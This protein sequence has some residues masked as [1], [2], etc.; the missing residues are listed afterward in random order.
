MPAH[1][2]PPDPEVLALRADKARLEDAIDAEYGRLAASFR[3]MAAELAGF[4]AHEGCQTARWWRPAHHSPSCR[5]IGEL[6]AVYLLH[7]DL[8]VGGMGV[9]T[10]L[11]ARASEVWSQVKAATAEYYAARRADGMTNGR[12]V[13][14]WAR[15]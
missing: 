9:D 3:D 13:R 6:V 7:A 1:P 4:N 12:N 14:A 11:T 10:G 15:S 5:A 2:L 8:L